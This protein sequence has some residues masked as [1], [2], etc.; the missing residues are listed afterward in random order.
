MKGNPLYDAPKFKIG[1]PNTVGSN[2]LRSAIA[3]K[4]AKIKGV[5]GVVAAHVACSNGGKGTLNGIFSILEEGDEVL[6]AGPGWPS[7]SNLFPAG[8][9]YVEVD[10]GGRGL[11]TPEQIR[12]ARREFPR[13]RS[14]LVNDRVNPTGAVYSDEEREG[15]F[16]AAGDIGFGGSSGKFMVWDNPYGRL[17][18]PGTDVSLTAGRWERSLF[19]N[20]GLV[21]IGTTSKN[22]GSPYLRIGWAVTTNKPL[23]EQVGKFNLA[24]GTGVVVTSERPAQLMLLFGD[25]WVA[26]MA[27]TL[28]ER[29]TTLSGLINQ[30]SVTGTDGTPR[31]LKMAKPGAAIYGWI[32]CTELNGMV[33]PGALMADG[34]DCVFGPG[35]AEHFFREQKTDGVAL[36]GGG[37]FYAPGSPFAGTK[38]FVRVVL[39]GQEQ[40]AARRMGAAV[41]RLVLPGR[42]IDATTL[43]QGGPQPEGR[44]A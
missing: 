28:G 17:I 16:E 20:G 7:N 10:T 42:Q 2:E 36:I 18:H 41:S 30:I 13:L 25:E 15:V 12:R 27:R 31:S 6:A 21:E 32:D 5:Q 26:N 35:T 22:F 14:I 34:K 38:T 23:L 40:E 37:P 4:H 39:V 9:R 1:Y 44:V 43:A 33:I 8:V 29:A 3:F 11:M 24:R 19:A